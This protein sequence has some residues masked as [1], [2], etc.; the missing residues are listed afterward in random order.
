VGW[1]YIWLE[2]DEFKTSAVELDDL[3]GLGGVAVGVGL[4]CF[5]D[6]CRVF[7]LVKQMSTHQTI[8]SEASKNEQTL[9]F[10]HFQ[11]KLASPLLPDT[12]FC[13]YFEVVGG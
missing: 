2:L 5:F 1:T 7:S 4:G 13:S 9:Q 10:L 3:L 8:L 11:T 12:S 6:G